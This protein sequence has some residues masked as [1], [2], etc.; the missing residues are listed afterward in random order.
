MY[1]KEIFQKAGNNFIV[2]YYI[3]KSILFLD[4]P[5]AYKDTITTTN[6]CCRLFQF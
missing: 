4:L 6:T 3:I 2:W 5:K 1:Q